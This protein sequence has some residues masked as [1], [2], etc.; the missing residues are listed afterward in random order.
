MK[1]PLCSS[2][3]TLPNRFLFKAF[4]VSIVFPQLEREED[5]NVLAQ[6]GYLVAAFNLHPAV[7]HA[8][9]KFVTEKV[10]NIC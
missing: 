1:T 2:S 5:W 9:L 8:E 4:M 10:Q 7:R 6:S 3:V